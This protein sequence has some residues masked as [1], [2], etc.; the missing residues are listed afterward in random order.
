MVRFHRSLRNLIKKVD[1]EGIANSA[2]DY[3]FAFRKYK[4][5]LGE[6]RGDIVTDTS[7]KASIK[8][9]DQIERDIIR[10]EKKM[11]TLI[12]RRAVE[13]AKLEEDLRYNLG[14]LDEYLE[15]EELKEFMG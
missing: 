15:P 1:P 9:I 2:E 6:L 5:Y 8:R 7:I 4:K 11:D 12:E 3:L 14:L 13:A 10:L